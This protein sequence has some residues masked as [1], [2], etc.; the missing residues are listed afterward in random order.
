M[1]GARERDGQR[2]TYGESLYKM[3][4]ARERRTVRDGQR[5]TDREK[6]CEN[7]KE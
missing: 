5:E 7:V 1:Q 6:V 3:Q 4:G 2:E